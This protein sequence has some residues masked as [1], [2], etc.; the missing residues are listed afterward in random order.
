VGTL[1]RPAGGRCTCSRW[2]QLTRGGAE[3]CARWKLPA[4]AGRLLENVKDESSKFRPALHDAICSRL[5]VYHREV[6]GRT[7]QASTGISCMHLYTRQRTSVERLAWPTG[8]RPHAHALHVCVIVSLL[9]NGM[10]HGRT[11]REC[12]VLLAMQ[13]S[14]AASC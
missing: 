10:K 2:Q 9:I 5:A 4:A 3:A 6:A 13:A 1:Q 12:S 8:V 11:A 7:P 14:S